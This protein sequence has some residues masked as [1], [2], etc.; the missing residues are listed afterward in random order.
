VGTPDDIAGVAAFLAGPESSFITG[1][2]ILVA[3]GA[4]A[5][6]KWNENQ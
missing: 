3:G 6:G 4:V 2:N 5:A 1:N